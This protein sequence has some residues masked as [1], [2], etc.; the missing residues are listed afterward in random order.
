MLLKCLKS[1]L[2]IWTRLLKL[3]C[4][5]GMKNKTQFFSPRVNNNIFRYD[6]V[7]EALPDKSEEKLP[8][9]RLS[10]IAGHPRCRKM[11]VILLQ[12]L[13]VDPEI[14]WGCEQVRQESYCHRCGQRVRS[15]A[16]RVRYLWQVRLGQWSSKIFAHGLRSR[17]GG[18]HRR[19]GRGWAPLL[20]SGMAG[21]EL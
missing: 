21:Q 20:P 2:P 10:V 15:T 16:F 11:H 18:F 4:D 12:V 5:W 14:K 19:A 1:A 8:N 17:C 6:P 9:A 3:L 7:A 13:T